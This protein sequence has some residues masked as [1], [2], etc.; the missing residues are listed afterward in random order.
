[1]CK[2]SFLLPN[3]VAFY[4]FTVNIHLEKWLM[5]CDTKRAI[6]WD[7]CNKHIFIFCIKNMST[8]FRTPQVNKWESKINATKFGIKNE[9]SHKIIYHNMTS[10]GNIIINI[11]DSCIIWFHLDCI[12]ELKKWYY[13]VTNVSSRNSA[14]IFVIS[15]T[16][17]NEFL[18]T[19]E[20]YHGRDDTLTH[21]ALLKSYWVLIISVQSIQ[22]QQATLLQILPRWSRA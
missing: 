15:P 7:L 3:L 5:R 13:I 17:Y 21:I 18:H 22:V 14:T 16:D 11:V 1:M 9:I 4:C 12:M 10:Y 8:I 6:W 19:F 20:P 2:I